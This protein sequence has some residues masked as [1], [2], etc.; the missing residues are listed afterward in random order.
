MS[1]VIDIA[2]KFTR[3]N[4]LWTPYIAAVVNDQHVKFARLDG[5]FIWHSHEHEDELFLVVRGELFIEFRERIAHL[6]SGQMC[7]VP[8]GVE[9]KPRTGPEGADVVLFEPSTTKHT[10]NL[11]TDRTVNHLEWI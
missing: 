4:K 2:S 5:E 11:E 10:G 1:D 6:T 8:K 9:H 3:I 7:V